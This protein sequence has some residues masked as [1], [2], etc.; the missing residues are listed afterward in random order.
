Q[1]VA[2]DTAKS[3]DG[4]P[5]GHGTT[6]QLALAGDRCRSLAPVQ[7][8]ARRRGNGFRRDAEMAVQILVGAAGPEGIHADED[9]IAADEAVP[10]LADARL[11]GDA[12]RRGA[13]DRLLITGG[14]LLEQLHARHRDD[15][16][17]MALGRQQL[18]RLERDLDF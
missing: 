11:D 15:A 5:D 3:V 17:R 7:F 6:L 13:D 14:L 18:A 8:V 16:H 9:A 12:H 1:D 4:Y 10:A 2:A